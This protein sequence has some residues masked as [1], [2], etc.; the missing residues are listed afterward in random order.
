MKTILLEILYIMAGLV[1][2]FTAY[3]ALQDK[4]HPTRIGSTIF[5]ALLAFAFISVSMCQLS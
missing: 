1:A 3:L 2:L 5:W 4:K